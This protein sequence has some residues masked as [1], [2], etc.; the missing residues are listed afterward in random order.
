MLVHRQLTWRRRN[1]CLIVNGKNY[2]LPI[3]FVAKKLNIN[4]F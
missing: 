2:M 4:L 1:H 3:V